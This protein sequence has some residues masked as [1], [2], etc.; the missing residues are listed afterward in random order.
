MVKTFRNDK[1]QV[2]H[3]AETDTD[4]QNS[5]TVTCPATGHMIHLAIYDVID[6]TGT[7]IR[8]GFDNRRWPSMHQIP[9]P[10]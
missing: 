4:V 6:F 2:K 5:V 3:Y 7:E 10:D 1:A 9:G 8:S